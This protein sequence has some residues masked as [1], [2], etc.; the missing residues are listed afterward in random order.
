MRYVGLVVGLALLAIGG[1]AS[2]RSRALVTT[3]IA[4]P[5]IDVDEIQIAAELPDP[6]RLC[7]ED[8]GKTPT[9]ACLTLGALR[10]AIFH[11]QFADK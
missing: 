3:T 10:T 5:A 4:T 8:L 9:W 2:H 6:V 1:C 11:R 7:V